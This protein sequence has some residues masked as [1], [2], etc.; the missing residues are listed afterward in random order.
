M[1]SMTLETRE[2]L[3]HLQKHQTAQ[4]MA[5]GKTTLDGRRKADRVL[6]INHQTAE[7]LVQRGFAR[8]TSDADGFDLIE[9]VEQS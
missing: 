6:K 4:V 2:A 1:R 3:E 9:L 5:S 8:Y 7:A